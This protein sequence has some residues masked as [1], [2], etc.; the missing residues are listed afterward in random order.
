MTPLDWTFYGT[1]VRGWLY[2]ALIALLSFAV[3]HAVKSIVVRRLATIAER[4]RNDYDDLA[5][6]L[7]R[8][9]A[10]PVLF[11]VAL[12]IGAQDLALPHIAGR[13]LEVA[14]VIATVLQ[15]AVWGNLVIAF[16]I[17]RHLKQRLA[18]DPASATTLNALGFIARLLLW[19][20]LFLLGLDNLGIDITALVAG[21][22]VGGIAVALAVQNILGD[23]FAS[24]SI[25]LDKPFVLGDFI[26]VDELMGTVEYIGLK[27]TR[28]RSISG[29]QIVCSNTDL[30]KTRIRN[31]KRMF[32]RRVVFTVGL[33]YGTPKEKL[34][35]V[36]GIVRSLVEAQ[37]GTR[38][39]RCHFKSYGAF[40]LDFETVYFV[41]D[42]DYNRYMDIHQTLNLGIYEEF[43][44]EGLEFAFPTQTIQLE[45]ATAAAGGA[46]G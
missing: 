27:T 4:T 19:T 10:S 44:K 42:P 32:E 40:S 6:D 37:D 7:L 39:D 28:L 15:A 17:T 41:L 12:A 38:F 1:P 45:G 34:A 5:V 20:V 18:E 36:P 13:G 9:L 35:R 43:E 23:L 16:F 26:I 29:E 33:V 11:I 14:L 24:L 8:R 25:V 3:L 31:Y 21:L 46:A 2:A 22:G 30:L